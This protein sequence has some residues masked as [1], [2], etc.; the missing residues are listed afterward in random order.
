MAKRT[1]CY[2]FLSWSHSC[3][4]QR[5]EGIKAKE[6]PSE[7]SQRDAVGAEKKT[8]RLEIT[9]NNRDSES[10]ADFRCQ[11]NRNGDISPRWSGRT[12]TNC[13]AE[14]WESEAG[15]GEGT[16]VRTARILR[17]LKDEKKKKARFAWTWIWRRQM[18]SLSWSLVLN[19]ALHTFLSYRS[20]WINR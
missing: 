4:L 20:Q 18:N 19:G 1:R 5:R 2:C 14:I 12:L 13:N 15:A 8:I 11:T 17:A 6:A 7:A 3:S 10:C 9:R 16:W